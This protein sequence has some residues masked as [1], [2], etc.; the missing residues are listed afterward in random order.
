MKSI[1]LADNEPDFLAVRVQFLE[2]AGYRVYTAGSPA[3]AQR[4]LSDLR[5][6]VAIL[7]IRLVDDDDDKDT[8]GL[9]LAKD[10]AYRLVPKIILTQHPTFDAVREALGPVLDGLPP[11]VAFLEK[12]EGVEEMLHAIEWALAHH[13]RLNWDLAVHWD[14]QGRLG[15][16]ALANALSDGLPTELLV[17]RAGELEDLFR[18]LFYE[19]RQI[20]IG[21]LLWHGG[22]RLCMPVW[23][24]SPQGATDQ[25]LLVC[26]TRDALTEETTRLRRLAPS[27]Q[28]GVRL[29]STAET[30]HF[31]AV[32]YS[33]PDAD[34]ET[35]QPLRDLFLGGSER[36]VRPA[37]AHLVQEVLR[38]WHQHGRTVAEGGDL[39]ALYRQRAGLAE[40]GLPRAEVERRVQV[41][42]QAARCLGPVEMEGDGAQLTF[43]FPQ[44][45]RLVCPDPVATV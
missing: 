7:D 40:R 19:A 32:V 12:K 21:R 27:T 24:Q 43:R 26:G 4:L 10:P 9:T 20:R 44:E 18:K 37:F 39:I 38:A 31:S 14:P 34:L 16:L 25:R 29:E 36:R 17:Q 35:V 1:L 15:F 41:L 22:G 6:H 5:L 23:A 42:L 8:S 28:S 30:V 45:S 2:R 3:E 13:L 11:A 33:L